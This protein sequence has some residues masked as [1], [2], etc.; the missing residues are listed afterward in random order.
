[1]H[2]EMAKSMI[3]YRFDRLKKAIQKARSRGLDGALFPWESDDTGEESTPTWCLTG[4]LELH[5]SADIAIATF[6]Y[7]QMTHDLQWLRTEGY[8][9]IREIA[10]FW[11]SKASKNSDGTFSINNVIGPNEYKHEADDNAFTNGAASLA[12][13]YASQAASLCGEIP[14]ILWTEIAQNIRF[15]YLKN[16]VTK[17]HNTYHGEIIKQAD[18]TLLGYPL[19]IISTE[20]QKKDLE[21]YTNKIDSI[22][23]PAMSFSSYCVQYARLGLVNKAFEAFKLSYTKN[24]RP[25][26]NVFAETPTS[27]NAY[28][29]TGAGGML[30]AVICGFGGLDLNQSG[31]IQHKSVLPPHWKKLIIKG[32]G[33]KKETFVVTQN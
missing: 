31:I 29:C 28:F 11:A 20:Q 16:G 22:N 5:I 26:F 9:L 23:G 30:Q 17:E 13:Q 4:V 24:L 7:Y 14:P 15:N 12:L 21:Y 3:D 6:N 27:N 32:V 25:P 8:P 1:M 2:P 18:V 10:R 33:L 19:D